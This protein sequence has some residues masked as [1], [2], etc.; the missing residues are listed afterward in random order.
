MPAYF[1]L[2][3]AQ[4]VKSYLFE[5]T[6]F[7]L[8]NM[9]ISCQCYSWFP[10]WPVTT[11]KR[12]TSCIFSAGTE[13]LYNV[14]TIWIG[15]PGIWLDRSTDARLVEPKTPS[16]RHTKLRKNS[17]VADS[18]LAQ[19]VLAI[20][21]ANSISRSSAGVEWLWWRN[22]KPIRRAAKRRSELQTLSPLFHLQRWKQLD[23]Q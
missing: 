2:P 23:F 22:R 14:V 4:S 8:T 7:E 9:C 3:F 19:K 10:L 16:P 12:H 18:S 6:L 5:I 1:L 21:E 15:F 13:P 17:K 11:V 20:T